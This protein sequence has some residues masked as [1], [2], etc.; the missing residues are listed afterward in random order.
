MTPK[1]IERVTQEQWLTFFNEVLYQ[2]KVLQ[3]KEYLAMSRNIRA[4]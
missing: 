4:R 2:K 1:Q 3:Q